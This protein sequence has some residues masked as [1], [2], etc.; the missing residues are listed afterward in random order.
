MEQST[1]N[2]HSSHHSPQT[3]GALLAKPFLILVLLVIF[4]GAGFYGGVTYEKN[5]VTKSPPASNAAYNSS[6]GSGGYGSRFGGQRPTVGSVTAISPSSIS[7]Q[8]SRTGSTV[9]LSITSSTAI[10]DS[11][12]TVTTSDI[13][14]GDTVVVVA[15]SSSSNQASR[16]LVNP[17]YG[18]GN[19]SAPSSTS[20]D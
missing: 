14:T 16:I 5:H 17:S 8:D 7:V 15:S 2:S 20:V 18:G 19:N 4:T 12:Q 3:K 10:T 1:S 13:Q 6:S 9:T 11:G